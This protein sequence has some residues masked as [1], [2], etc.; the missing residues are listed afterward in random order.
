MIDKKT[1]IIFTKFCFD[2]KLNKETIDWSK[3]LFENLSEMP[4]FNSE[5]PYL[6]VALCILTVSRVEESERTAS[7]VAGVF[8]LKESNLVDL[9]KML[10]LEFEEEMNEHQQS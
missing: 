3:K 2:L 1:E 4:L 8:H 10:I 5:S 7:D 9:Y 6:L